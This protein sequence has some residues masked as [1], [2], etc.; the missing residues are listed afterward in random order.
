MALPLCTDNNRFCLFS[1]RFSSDGSEIVGGSNNGYI[2][3]FDREANTQSLRI[4]FAIV[5]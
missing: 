5:V 3:L 1:V 4:R 2:Y